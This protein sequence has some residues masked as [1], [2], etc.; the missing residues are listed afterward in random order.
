M[1]DWGCSFLAA[2]FALLSCFGTIHWLSWGSTKNLILLAVIVFV[3]V[4][5]TAKLLLLL[6]R[7]QKAQMHRHGLIP[8]VPGLETEMNSETL[9]IPKDEK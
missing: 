9:D 3:P 8:R 5:V 4:M 6:Y 2:T 1:K 7:Y